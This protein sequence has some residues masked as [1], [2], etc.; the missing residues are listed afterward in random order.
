MHLEKLDMEILL[1][2]AVFADEYEV[3]YLDYEV[4]GAIYK[5]LE[6]DNF[7]TFPNPAVIGSFYKKL[8]ESN[9]I[10]RFFVDVF[11]WEDRGANG[12]S[13]KELK[14]MMAQYPHE[15]LTEVSVER[16][17]PPERGRLGRLGAP[18]RRMPEYEYYNYVCAR[19]DD[20]PVSA[21]SKTTKSLPRRG[22]VMRTCRTI[23]ATQVK[24]TSKP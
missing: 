7:D 16:D 8:P 13:R 24:M 19:H 11:L 15:F 18:Y 2:L 6:L 4:F 14:Q 23:S 3:K 10:R 12:R 20:E 9:P 21:D 17:I 22:I 5:K 1:V